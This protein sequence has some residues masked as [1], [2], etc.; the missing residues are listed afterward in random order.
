MEEEENQ[1]KKKRKQCW[2]RSW[3]LERQNKGS[4][5]QLLQELAAHDTVA[6]ESYMQNRDRGMSSTLRGDGTN[7]LFHSKDTGRVVEV[8][9]KI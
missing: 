5:H 8:I 4:F 9:R 6:F 1:S 7:M 3:M 2:V